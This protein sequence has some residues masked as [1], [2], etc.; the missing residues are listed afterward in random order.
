MFTKLDE[1]K[2]LIPAP[3]REPPT[4]QIVEALKANTEALKALEDEFKN[5]RASATTKEELQNALTAIEGQTSATKHMKAD[6]VS[7]AGKFVYD[8]ATEGYQDTLK[9]KEEIKGMVGRALLICHPSSSSTEGEI[10]TLATRDD[11]MALG[12]QYLTNLNCIAHEQ[13]TEGKKLRAD[14]LH[15]VAIMK[16]KTDLHLNTKL[17]VGSIVGKLEDATNQCLKKLKRK[18]PKVCKEEVA[19]KRKD[20]EGHDDQDPSHHEREEHATEHTTEP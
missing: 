1:F 17:K 12:D 6:I 4:N 13:T 7:E 5:L 9:L 18:A 19:K 10:G 20:D 3:V 14:I 16:W 11:F 2:S 8:V 15:K